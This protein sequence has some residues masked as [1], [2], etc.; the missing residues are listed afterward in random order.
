MRTFMMPR[1]MMLK[2]VALWLAAGC[3][4]MHGT[5]AFTGGSALLPQRGIFVRGVLSSAA[6]RRSL[7]QPT[8]AA[9]HRRRTALRMQNAPNK[10]PNPLDLLVKS[11]PASR[12]GIDPFVGEDA[13]VFDWANEKWGA[14]GERGW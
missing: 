9:A 4:G 1:K 3:A 6:S 11:E 10:L 5:H 2:T 12:E 14:L 7:R 13:A 8:E